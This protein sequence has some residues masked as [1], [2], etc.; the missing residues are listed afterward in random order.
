MDSLRFFCLHEACP[1]RKGFA[2]YS[3]LQDH[4]AKVHKDKP[5]YVDLSRG[6]GSDAASF[7]LERCFWSEPAGSARG[8]RATAVELAHLKVSPGQVKRKRQVAK[9]LFKCINVYL[10]WTGVTFAELGG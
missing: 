1:R 7:Q 8:R 6:K 2:W 10:G 3:S 9:Q 5:D 4:N